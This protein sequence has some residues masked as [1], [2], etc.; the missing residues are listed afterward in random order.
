MRIV[1]HPGDEGVGAGGKIGERN[2][3]RTHGSSTI[4]ARVKC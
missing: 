4:P 1:L 2:C 3:L